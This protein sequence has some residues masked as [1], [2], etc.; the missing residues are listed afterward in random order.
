MRSL[1]SMA[2]VVFSGMLVAAP[3]L[4]GNFADHGAVSAK[5]KGDKVVVTVTGKGDWRVNGEYNTKVELGA[6]KATKADGKFEGLKDG[7]A[8]SV[9]F[10]LQDPAKS[11]KVKAVFCDKQSC[12]APLSMTFDVK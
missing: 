2:M 8:A 10:E 5:R 6:A 12:T 1:V 11:G 7:K 4:A 9:T 3:A